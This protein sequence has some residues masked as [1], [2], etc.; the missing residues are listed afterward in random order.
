[1]KKST[2]IALLVWAVVFQGVFADVVTVSDITGSYETDGFEISTPETDYENGIYTTYNTGA[3][4]LS[5]KYYKGQIVDIYTY[6]LYAD[7]NDY[8]IQSVCASGGGDYA[9]WSCDVP[10]TN[11]DNNP[12]DDEIYCYCRLKRISDN[13]SSVG[14]V[15]FAG[16]TV[17][18]CARLCA[19]DCA[20]YV[21]EQPDFVSAL[22]AP[23]EP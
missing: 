13:V 22:L 14:W 1:M 8:L 21:S 19:H 12:S 3:Q 15:F 7:I 11:L 16:N 6:Y 4:Y 2:I 17:D 9:E 20:Y 23:F 5:S 10:R 18:Y